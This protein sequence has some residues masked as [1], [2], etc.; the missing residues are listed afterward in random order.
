VGTNR[1]SIMHR[2]LAR[3]YSQ[4]LPLKILHSPVTMPPLIEM[5]QWHKYRDRDPGRIWL[6]ELLR[7][8]LESSPK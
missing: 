6:F 3:A 1:I 5:I 2:R 7:A 4:A 8:A